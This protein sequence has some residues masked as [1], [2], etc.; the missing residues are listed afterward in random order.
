M[1]QCT[2][3]KEVKPLEDFQDHPETA[4]GRLNQCRACVSEYKRQYYQK[5]KQNEYV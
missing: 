1:K 4:D 5:R 3:C 2:K